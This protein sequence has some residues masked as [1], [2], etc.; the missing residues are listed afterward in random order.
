MA[1]TPLMNRLQ[2]AADAA[3]TTAAEAA[4]ATIQP[5][6]QRIAAAHNDPVAGVEVFD[7]QPLVAA[8]EVGADL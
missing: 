2:D 8:L 6:A 3:P 1:R 4:P 5:R 7:R